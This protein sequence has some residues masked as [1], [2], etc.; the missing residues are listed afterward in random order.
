MIIDGHGY[1]N[2]KFQLP[3]FPPLETTSHRSCDNKT[4]TKTDCSWWRE[5]K[6]WNEM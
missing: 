5:I 6:K 3:I 4:D 2:L 1:G